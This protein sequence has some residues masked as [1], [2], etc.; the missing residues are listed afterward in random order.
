MLIIYT[1][2]CIISILCIMMSIFRDSNIYSYLALSSIYFGNVHIGVFSLFTVLIKRLKIIKTKYIRSKFWIIFW[3]IFLVCGLVSSIYNGLGLRVVNQTIEIIALIFFFML[4]F[5][6]KQTKTALYFYVLPYIGVTLIL[7]NFV[8]YSGWTSN[9]M[10]LKGL[11]ESS[12]IADLFLIAIIPYVLKKRSFI[13]IF[14]TLII[15]AFLI[16]MQARAGGFVALTLVIINI[17]FYL[18]RN[19]NPLKKFLFIP[20]ITLFFISLIPTFSKT[21]TDF[22]L[23]QFTTQSISNFERFLMVRHSF[24]EISKKPIFGYG[25]G[26]IEF[27]MKKNETVISRHPHPH[28]NTLAHLAIEMGVFGLLLYILIIM[29]LLN[30]WYYFSRLKSWYDKYYVMNILISFLLLSNV[31]SIFYGF[32]RSLTLIICLSFIE[33]RKVYIRDS[34]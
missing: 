20:I 24:S 29:W 7:L 8:V 12:F 19:L 31:Q 9:D 6:F 27:I 4:L 2:F 33:F 23:N 5:F 14:I 21:V 13:H 22:K 32:D 3:S 10:Y 26:T 34:N 17:L 16:F 18:F 25:L 30:A 11:N 28:N 15:I 1:F